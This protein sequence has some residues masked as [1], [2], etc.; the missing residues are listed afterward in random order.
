MRTNYCG[1]IDKKFLKQDVTVCGW[2]HR[3]RDHGGL[4]FLDLRDVSG[5]VQLVINPES[6]KKNKK[7][8]E[9]RSEYVL[10]ASGTVNDRPEDSENQA[11]TTG[12]IEIVV[13]E[14]TVLNIVSWFDSTRTDDLFFYDNLPEPGNTKEFGYSVDSSFSKYEIEIL[15]MDSK[16][17]FANDYCLYEK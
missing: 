2:V 8:E 11:L 12:S 1:E 3:R 16:E 5:I 7:A 14:L 6:E 15:V 9:V 4:I 10:Q 17:N 13:S